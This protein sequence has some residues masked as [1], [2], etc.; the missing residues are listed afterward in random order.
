M[1]IVI[2]DSFDLL[3]S[4][5][6]QLEAMGAEIYDD[7]PD[8]EQVVIERIADADA[9]AVG[10]VDITQAVI[11]QSPQLKYIIVAA[12]GYDQI[13]LA[14]ANARGIPVIN[15]PTHNSRAVAEYT[16]GL[17]L[18]VT[19]QIGA[20]QNAIAQ[21]KWNPRAHCGLELRGRRLVL[22]GHGHI[23]QQVAQLAKAFGMTVDWT[24]SRTPAAELDRLIASADILSLHLPLNEQTRQLLDAR[25][26]GLMQTHAYLINTARGDIVDQAALL[27][28]LQQGQI[29]GAALDVFASEPATG[30][31]PQIEAFL[32]LE[33]AIA[34]PHIAYNTAET[35]DRLGKELIANLEACL[36]GEP[37]NV[38]NQ[39][40]G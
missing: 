5:R 13:D 25:R 19:R 7:I 16:I 26:I 40:R 10:W 31:P 29:A 20:A 34:T 11:E 17:M 15:C 36:S 2:P 1:K 37:I 4:D 32:E 18:A 24:D 39:P 33:N 6:Q 27:D 12:V 28:A 38:V 35:T 3:E 22:L 30:A 9:I 21:G 8:S 14:A 23:G